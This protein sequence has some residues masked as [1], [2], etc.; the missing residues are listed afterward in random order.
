MKED[1][2]SRIKTTVPIIFKDENPGIY[3]TN[4]KEEGSAN[5]QL[6]RFVESE[7]EDAKSP[8]DFPW[9][10]END[11]ERTY[12]ICLLNTFH[13]GSLKQIEDAFD[14][15]I[16]DGPANRWRRI[17]RGPAGRI[18]DNVFPPV[19]SELLSSIDLGAHPI[20]DADISI[21]SSAEDLFEALDT[22]PTR[23]INKTYLLRYLHS[24]FRRKQ[25]L[26]E[27]RSTSAP[28]SQPSRPKRSLDTFNRLKPKDAS[29]EWAASHLIDHIDRYSDHVPASILQAQNHL[30]N[31][32]YSTKMRVLNAMLRLWDASYI[33]RELYDKNFSNNLGVRRN[34]AKNSGRVALSTKISP[35]SKTQLKKLATRTGKKQYEVIEDLI[36]AAFHNKT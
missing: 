21:S 8:S 6:K 28:N 5:A 18:E 31:T 29:E 32:E 24:E 33:E 16:N 4:L 12:V 17:K 9:L 27:S 14:K 15:A 23:W 22:F 34:R 20:K 13:R 1:R 36:Y 19:S 26:I 3:S 11:V 35:E 10:I 25:K 7:I 2:I 30:Q